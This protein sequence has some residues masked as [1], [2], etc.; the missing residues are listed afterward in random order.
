[1]AKIFIGTSG[2]FYPHWQDIF[3]PLGL[4]KEDF[5]SFYCRYFTTVEINSSFYRLPQTKIVENWFNR[6]PKNFV[7]SFKMSRTIT[8]LKK[9]V[10]DSVGLSFLNNFFRVLK[11]LEKSANR[12]LI[13]FQLPPFLKAN[14][15]KLNKIFSLLPKNFLYAFEF[16]HSSWFDKAIYKV[17]KKYNTA[18]VLS[19]NPGLW[20][21]INIETANFFY[22]RLH[23]SKELFTSSYTDNELN[24]Y[25][26]LMKNKFK[27]GLDVFC[28]FN[29]DAGGA[30]VVNAQKLSRLVL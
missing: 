7:F 23:G 10:F 24:F 13:L 5:F 6:A 29:N 28:Y 9:L 16:R 26:K 8:H 22:L 14:P 20:P 15:K 21:K 3:Y 18:V 19:D 17:L 12:H 27:K 2:F 30:A 11:P 25:A 1:M 4:K